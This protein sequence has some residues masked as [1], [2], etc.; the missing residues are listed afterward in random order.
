[1]NKTSTIY[2]TRTLA[3]SQSL[4]YWCHDLELNL[5]LELDNISTQG[6]A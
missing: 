1:M 3:Q 4:G 5:G 2:I 6:M